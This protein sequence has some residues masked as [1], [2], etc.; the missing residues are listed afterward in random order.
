MQDPSVP[1]VASIQAQAHL[2]PKEGMQ[3][4]SVWLLIFPCVLV[5]PVPH[6]SLPTHR[7]R[8][9]AAPESWHC[10]QQHTQPKDLQSWRQSQGPSDMLLTQ[11]YKWTSLKTKQINLLGLT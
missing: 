5:A 3:A 4:C 2:A 6:S 9:S 1:S 8:T 11:G 7:A 10:E